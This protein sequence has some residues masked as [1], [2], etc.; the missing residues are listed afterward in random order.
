MFDA[1]PDFAVG[2]EVQEMVFRHGKFLEARELRTGERHVVGH[3]AVRIRGK[4]IVNPDVKIDPLFAIDVVPKLGRGHPRAVHQVL[5]V[6]GSH[7]RF[8]VPVLPRHGCGQCPFL[9]QFEVIQHNLVTQILTRR[10]VHE[11]IHGVHVE[12]VGLHAG[13]TRVEDVRVKRPSNL[14]DMVGNRPGVQAG[15]FQLVLASVTVD[16]RDAHDV[17][18]KIAELVSTRSPRRQLQFPVDG[19]DRKFRLE[20]QVLRLD[21]AGHSDQDS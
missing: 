8:A 7:G 12:Q 18:A 11:A 21:V 17:L 2:E 4:A 13:R 9:I 6:T 5:H 10:I 19:A 3:E 14:A 15:L 20:M 1:V 16:P